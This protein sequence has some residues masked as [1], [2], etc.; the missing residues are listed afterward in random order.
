MKNKE[1]AEK[2]TEMVHLLEIK[3]ENSFKIRSY[4]KAAETIE[5]L[6]RDIEEYYLSGNLEKIDGIGKGIAG[7][8]QQY[9]SAGKITKLEELRKEVP[10]GLLEMLKVPGLGP[11]KIRLIYEKLGVKTMR[12]LDIAVRRGEL[13]ALPGMGE[14]NTANIAR[15]LEIAN[16]MDGRLLMSTAENMAEEF[17]DVLRKDKNCREAFVCGSVRRGCETIGDIDLLAV[18]DEPEKITDTFVKIQGVEKVIAEGPAKASVYVEGDVRIDLR[19]VDETSRA[20]AMLYFTGSKEHNIA[21]RKLALKKGLTLNEYGLYE[22]KTEKYAAGKK[23]SE[24]YGRLGLQFIPPELR[25]NRGEIET[26]GRNALPELVELKD[27]KGDLHLHSVYSDGAVQIRGLAARAA[28]LGYEWIAVCDHSV[29]LRIARGLSIKTLMKKK[30]EIEHLNK[31]SPVR[32]L[33][34]AEVDILPDGKL[35]Y[36]DKILKGLDICLGAIHSAF[37][38]SPEELNRRVL[39]AMDNPYLDILAHPTARLIGKRPPL[40]LD[41]EKITDKAAAKKIILEVNAF[42][43]RRD[44][45]EDHIRMAMG[46]G[47]TLS[48]GTD[49]HALHHMDNMR[50]GLMNLRRSGCEKKDVLNTRSLDELQQVIRSRRNVSRD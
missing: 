28:E 22:Q 46:K 15:G 23:E 19:V 18:S 12:G 33:F 38:Q 5:N 35:D 1:I 39:T 2:F 42:P 40:A 41:M 30:K 10:R 47:V 4:E 36:P 16:R 3:G 49:S 24:I 45:K 6:D 7:K 43:D 29:S 37:K 32:I 48:L 20:A 21:L 50:Y 26:A 17:L 25:E 34:G 13:A 44:L 9:L 8:I 14:K 11:V 27:I 31:T